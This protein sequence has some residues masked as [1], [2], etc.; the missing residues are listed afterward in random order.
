MI[1]DSTN[2]ILEKYKKYI[3]PSLARLLKL[4]GCNTV[5]WKADGAIIQGT[6]GEKFIDCLGGYGVF[7]IGHRHTKVVEA[8]EDQLHKMPLS[9]RMLLSQPLADLSEWLARITPGDLRYS[10]ICNSGAEAVEG[11]LKLARLATGRSEIVSAE[12]AFHGKTFGALSA[13]G[14]ERYKQP[15]EPLLPGFKQVPFGDVEALEEC[16]TDRTAAVV[17]EPIQGEGGIIVPPDDYLPEVSE[18]CRRTGVLLIMDEIQTG[19]GRTGKLF[20]V[21]HY[22]VVPDIMTSAKALGG[23][24]MPIGAFIAT[25]EVWKPFFSR[26][27]IHTSTFGGNPLACRA[28]IAAIEV[29]QEEKLT[30]RARSLGEYFLGRLTELQMAYPDVIADVRGKG[31]LIGV[32]LTKEGLGGMIVPEMIKRKVLVAFTLNNPKVIRLEP[33]LVIARE[34]IDMVLRAFE[35][36]LRKARGFVEKI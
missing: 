35:E 7:N 13:S 2:K 18:L 24:V 3:N 27:L 5:E 19:L 29:I 22:G 30:D 12:N 9:S 14:R 31:L 28:A 20:A 32:E 33:P 16:I 1:M 17:L 21:E 6:Q 34:Q 15:F 23:G 11:A 4:M 25:P 8:V 36:A 10:F 26:P